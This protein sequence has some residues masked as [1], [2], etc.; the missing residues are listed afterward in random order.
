MLVGLLGIP[1]V[2]AY[3]DT[4]KR[5]PRLEMSGHECSSCGPVALRY[6]RSTPKT[7]GALVRGSKASAITRCEAQASAF[8]LRS[9]IT[10]VKHLASARRLASTASSYR[11]PWR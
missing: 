10:T 5:S 11:Q 3:Q 8:T 9:Q 7:A 6:E 4:A 2:G 1:G